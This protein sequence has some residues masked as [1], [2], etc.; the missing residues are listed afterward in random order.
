MARHVADLE[1]IRKT[2]GA[3]RLVLAGTGW[4]TTLATHY[5]LQFPDQVER[6]ILES[7]G[8]LWAPAWPETINP[9][10]RATM[11]DVQASAL[12]ALERPPLRLVLGRM[13]ADFSPRWRW[14]SSRTATSAPTRS[15]SPLLAPRCASAARRH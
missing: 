14:A 7:P 5:L 15:R 2:V 9:S 1:A 10:A 12:A 13:M 11:T 3:P 4:G 8:A 6:P